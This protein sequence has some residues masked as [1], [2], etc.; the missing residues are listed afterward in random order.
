MGKERNKM[1]VV[2]YLEELK[3][4][5]EN[6]RGILL[7]QNCIIDREYFLHTLEL[8]TTNLPG[9]L[10]NAK[11][12]IKKG[13][14]II[15]SAKQEGKRIIEDSHERGVRMLDES[16]IIKQTEEIRDKILSS[17]EAEA[18]DIREKAYNYAEDLVGNVERSLTDA[19]LQIQKDKQGIQ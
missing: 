11:W 7:S 2:D 6:A 19:L 13:E 10:K 12:I 18:A 14:E 3:G 16:A 8:I 4:R 9:E 1:D 15:E 17:A 5:V